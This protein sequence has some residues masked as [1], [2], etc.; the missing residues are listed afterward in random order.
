MEPIYPINFEEKIGFDRIRTIL[1]GNCLSQLGKD[2]VEKMKFI[3]KPDEIENRVGQ[4]EEFYR[5]ITEFD[6]F[7]TNNFFDLRKALRKV[8]IEGAYI[9]VDELFDL[10][11]S[12]ESYRGIVSFFKNT[13]ELDFVRLKKLVT[14]I[15]ILNEVLRKIDQILDKHGKV[16]DNAS[17]ELQD[18]RR[19]IYST[20]GS[21]SKKMQSIVRQ[22]QSDGVIDTDVNV[23]I[24]EGRPVIPVAAAN[25]KKLN[26][27]IHDE[28]STGKTAF[29]E[30]SAIVEMNNRLKELQN[31]ERREVVKIL[32]SFTAELR[33]YVN[34]LSLAYSIMGTIDFIRA[35]AVFARDFECSKPNLKPFPFFDWHQ[36]K[37]PLL[38]MSLKKEN[39]SVIP[40]SIRMDDPNRI[41]LISGPNAGGKSVC[42]KTV[43]IIQYMLQCGMM[44]PI[45]EGSAMGIFKNIFIDIGDEQSLDNDL[46]TYSSHLMNMKYFSRNCNSKSLVLIDEFGT[47]TEPMLGGAIAEAVLN[48]L[49][50]LKTFGV[51]T[52][53]YT[54]L[55]HFGS[56]N[57]GI[58]NGA[59]LYNTKEMKPLF[60]LS[61]GKPGS[62]FA[63]EIARSIGLSTEI[64]NEATEKLGQEHIDYDKHLREIV[65][66]KQY[67]ETKRVKVRKTEKQ[68]DRLSTEYESELKDTQK[69]R[70]EIIAE[71]KKEAQKIIDDANKTIENTIRE[72]RES[73]AAKEKTKDIR[74]KLIDKKQ[75][76]DEIDPEKERRINQKIEKLKRKEQSKGKKKKRG[77][78]QQAVSKEPEFYK[79]SPGEKVR[80]IDSQNVGEIIDIDGNKAII[81]LGH[82]MSTVSINKIEPVSKS[83]IKKQ[84]QKDKLVPKASSLNLTNSIMDKKLKFKPDIDV[85]GQRAEEALGNIQSFIDEAIIV[86][87][88]TLRILHGKGFGVLKETIRDYLRTE[89]MVKSYRDEHIQL[90]GAGITIV[91]L[92]V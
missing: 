67:W 17:L 35:K 50:Q 66:D 73:Q 12:L 37:H 4:V 14:D 33:P 30:P 32:S 43:G 63:F 61:I 64:L 27:I 52:T 74:K 7:P 69:L 90:G 22:L 55:K 87:S 11:R 72:I 46:S 77:E 89:P 6:N 18:I 28:S 84:E 39:R 80:L 91:E 57:K 36:A 19:Q 88:K 86:G 8:D 49:N 20:Q 53:H 34:D 38:T 85:R 70:K 92:D 68:L 10:K 9:E 59:M 42:L 76:I 48:R 82:L 78:V 5:I 29:I 62:S 41:L 65:R 24:R 56:S 40:L 2:W 21:I 31:A 71:A 51:I 1:L 47:G 3:S 81:A 13:E 79:F 58:V 26:G 54:N 75:L 83:Q 15:H 16:K 60:Q 23:S 44:V 25:K 45:S